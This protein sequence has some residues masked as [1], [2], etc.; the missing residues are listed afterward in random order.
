MFKTDISSNHSNS[1]NYNCDEIGLST[2][3]NSP[4]I[5]LRDDVKQVGHVT[6]AE[7]DE[8]VSM[9]NFINK[10]GNKI[11]HVYIFPRVHF[12]DFLL[13]DWSPKSFA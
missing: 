12:K 7:R 6:L 5:I 13:V 11:P 1:D 8:L 4:K 2:V 10:T 3:T 9:L